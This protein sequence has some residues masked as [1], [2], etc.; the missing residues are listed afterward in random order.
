MQR[1]RWLNLLCVK[2]GTNFLRWYIIW[3]YTWNEFKLP[4]GTLIIPKKYSDNTK[5]KLRWYL[6]GAQM[7]LKKYT[8]GTQ[9]GLK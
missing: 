7:I 3:C 2:N 4:R 1:L 9:K 6:E 8:D 5:E